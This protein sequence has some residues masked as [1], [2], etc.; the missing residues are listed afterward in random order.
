MRRKLALALT[1]TIGIL[2][3][4]L[5]ATSAGAHL[6]V[7]KLGPPPTE[8]T[9]EAG[10]EC[11]YGLAP[12]YMGNTYIGGL[13][14]SPHLI[15]EGE[16]VTE[17]FYPK[18]VKCISG[19]PCASSWGWGPPGE[20]LSP[21]GSEDLSC[22]FKA[23]YP[24]AYPPSET[25]SGWSGGW[26]VDEL[27]ICGFNGCANASDYYYI[28]PGNLR[29]LS[30]SVRNSSG[31][32]LAG[33]IVNIEGAAGSET[34]EVDPTT[35]TYAVILPPGHYMVSV[36]APSG[37][38]VH[39]VQCTTGK[40]KGG[41]E[42]EIDLTEKDGIA[43]FIQSE[44]LSIVGTPKVAEPATG[45]TPEQFKIALSEASEEPVTVKWS[46][47]D[48]SATVAA[49]NY[50]EAGGEVTIPAGARSVPVTVQVLPGSGTIQTPAIYYFAK[51]VSVVSGDVTL[52]Q[53]ARS[54]LGTILAPGVTGR[55]TGPPKPGGGE[56]EGIAGV[57]VTLAGTAASGTSV[58]RT[59]TS[60]SNGEYHFRVDPGTYT[61]TPTLTAKGTTTSFNTETCEGEK[62][63]H[64]CKLTLAPGTN[65]YTANFTGGLLLLGKVVNVEG[66]GVAGVSVA[67]AGP[68]NTNV[69]TEKEGGFKAELA[70][71]T[72]TVTAQPHEKHE[73]F[74]VASEECVAE[75]SSCTVS[76]T[77]DRFVEF[78]E[79]VLPNE[80]GA[81]LPP[82]T[83]SPIP[84]AVTDGQLEAVGCFTKHSDGTYTSERNVRLDGVDVKPT[85][86]G[87]IVIDGTSVSSTTPALVK[88]D[89]FTLMEPG[90]FHWTYG[91]SSVETNDISANSPTLAA[92][93]NIFGIPIALGSG[94]ALSSPMLQASTGKTTFTIAAQAVVPFNTT[95]KWD[96]NESGFASEGKSVPSLGLSGSFVTTNRDGFQVGQFCGKVANAKPFGELGGEI[97]QVVLCWAPTKHEWSLQGLYN[98][99]ETGAKFIR[100]LNL[101]GSIV[102]NEH[103]P[104]GILGYR[105]QSVEV[106]ARG[107]GGEGGGVNG[108]P[109]GDGVFWNGIGGGWTNDLSSE[110]AKL[111]NFNL[112]GALTLGPEFGGQ[113]LLSLDGQIKVQPFSESEHKPVP[114][115]YE[116]EGLLTALHGTGLQVALG[117]AQF[118]YTYSPVV[119]AEIEDEFG[120]ALGP[121][122]GFKT[123]E[124]GFWDGKH[125]VL[126]LSGGGSIAV[127][128]EQLNAE[129]ALIGG[130]GKFEAV[131][132]V[133]EGNRA[134][135]ASKFAGGARQ[136]FYPSFKLELFTAGTCDIGKYKQPNPVPSASSAR[137][138][139]SFAIRLARHL[140]GTV[141]A[142]K[143]T[144][145]APLIA[146]SGPGESLTATAGET[147]TRGGH[148]MIVVDES[149]QTTYVVLDGPS[150]GDYSIVPQ[151]GSAPIASVMEADAAPLAK[152]TTHVSV[153]QCRATVSYHASVPR[154]V[155][156]SLYAQGGGSLQL[157]GR[158]HNGRGR[159]SFAAS[160][161]AGG[162][163]QIIALETQPGAARLPK[164]L[165]HYL[166]KA[167]RPRITGLHDRH[168]KVSWSPAGCG[169]VIYTVTV[170]SAAGTKELTVQGTAAKLPAG[171]G[172]ATVTVTAHGAAG[173]GPPAKLKVKL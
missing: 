92:A 119:S 95:A 89:G 53:K 10:L 131:V 141:L 85:E 107:L 30:G 128:A 2:S 133:T 60:E 99:P 78:T 76:L 43:S 32:P 66:E 168:G 5:D 146:I 171:K 12:L 167:T 164:H 73:Y 129:G 80:D 116:V 126:Q 7:A 151:A 106:Q 90:H 155:N 130:P 69:E 39:P 138:A 124:S 75:A 101:M 71:G 123:K 104:E 150:P 145:A 83:P 118:R 82:K 47:F 158:A 125:E 152:L 52:N 58:S 149:N 18:T 103:G 144:G 41:G 113:S 4:G 135:L 122:G 70:P 22:T 86:K 19:Q 51:I 21:C 36:D 93:P 139:G 49:G 33:A 1:V 154:G 160:P 55:I 62:Q 102:Y 8:C 170:R 105:L 77:K 31:E 140:A 136:V 111:K 169:P 159:A 81:P 142:V 68:E 28:V 120:L 64:S 26:E 44:S 84:G 54:A 143:G 34:V 132:C 40:V 3:A 72:Y 37:G 115:L 156:V 56:R 20:K 17:S 96:P 79:C 16:T 117:H 165:A 88:V 112:T 121:L 108:I 25:S 67:I 42:C 6:A 38:E 100:Q 163:G 24:S 35:G 114:S 27:G 127:G 161:L 134:N 63:E 91:G 94:G 61:V 110:P 46:T 148:A 98:L 23:I 29:G 15:H 162:S 87:S 13:H 50:K 9:D 14:I 147:L 173:A 97:S 166:V 65:L 74:P 11:A 153:A 137:S 172:S 45:S 57:T 59:T 157:I 109:L 48:S